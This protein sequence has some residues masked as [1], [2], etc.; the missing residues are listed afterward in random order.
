M[1]VYKLHIPPVNYT[2]E[3]NFENC[4]SILD[5]YKTEKGTFKVE[6]SWYMFEKRVVKRFSNNNN[7]E[8]MQEQ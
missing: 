5:K 7:T 4:F 6:K 1:Q 2:A 3:Y 8:I